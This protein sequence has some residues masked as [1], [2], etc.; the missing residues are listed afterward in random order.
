MKFIAVVVITA[1]GTPTFQLDDQLKP[2]GYDSATECWMR[3]SVMIRDITSKVP[4]TAA[5][6]TCINNPIEDRK[7][8]PKPNK[9]KTKEL[10]S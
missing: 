10:D 3:T 4:V 2:N 8:V 1:L 5:V 9:S 7:P 6:G